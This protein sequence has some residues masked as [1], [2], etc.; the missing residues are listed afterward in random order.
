MAGVNAIKPAIRTA[1]SS[2]ARGVSAAGRAAAQNTR[3]IANQGARRAASQT[4][5]TDNY[6]GP[7][8]KPKP[9]SRSRPSYARGQVRQ[10]WNASRN[11]Q[12]RQIRNGDLPLPPPAPNQ[13]WVRNR[14]GD[15]VSVSYRSP[16][17]RRPWDMGHL[18]RQ[19]YRD[20]HARY[21]RGE[22]SKREFLDWYRNPANYRVEHP[23]RNRA[24]MD[25]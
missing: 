2:M 22:M 20:F 11:A 1:G 16:N 19:Q 8:P 5:K 24:R 12:I 13:M 23:G 7:T 10:V 4:R 21:M 9:Y 3:N 6:K 14:Q 25:E 15:W 18:P 17:G